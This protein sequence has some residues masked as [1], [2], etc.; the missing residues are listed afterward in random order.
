V[1]PNLVNESVF[2][3][4]SVRQD[5]I[6]I[7]TLCMISEQK[8]IDTLLKA[9]ALWNP[10]A[11]LV[12]LRIAGDGPLRHHYAAMA[13]SL[14][15]DDRVQWLGGV[16]RTAAAKL[17]RE[18]SF[19]VL[20]S[21]HETFGV[22]FAEAIASGLPIVATRCGGPESI[23]NATNGRMVAVDDVAGLADAMKHVAENLDAFDPRAIRAD[24]E[25]RFSR[26]AVV[27]ELVKL[28]HAVA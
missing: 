14:R 20:P 16:D 1:I 18:S 24:F 23:V 19:F 3:P 22:V 11:R 8:G 25:T 15:I 5:P 12:Q 28:Y 17:Y 2:Y 27:R 7:L 9:F 13:T 10:P 6:V 4:A 26:K 21:R